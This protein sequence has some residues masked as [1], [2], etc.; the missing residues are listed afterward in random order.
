[1]MGDNNMTPADVAAVMGNRG[2]GYGGYGDGFGFGGGSWLIAILALLMFG[3]YGGG[4]GMGGMGGGMPWLMAGQQ[5]LGAQMNSGF[6]NAAVM[7]QLGGIQNA[8]TGGFGSQEVAACNRAMDSLA[9]Q[10]TNQIAE[11]QRSFAAQTDVGNR[12]DSIAM[13]LQNCCCENR[14]AT[15]DLKYTVATEA[16][17]DR[18]AVTAALTAVTQ[19]M[20]AGFQSILTQMSSDKL[21]AKNEKIAELQQ[22]IYMKDLAASQIAQTAQLENFI[23]ANAPATAA[24]AG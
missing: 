2:Y 7:G 15:A 3:G 19:Q 17:A 24:T 9:A 10:Y 1:M 23:R 5:N 13:S 14:A 21:D 6:D 18:A 11:L 22:Q 4:F 16:C 20:N 12:L 8:I